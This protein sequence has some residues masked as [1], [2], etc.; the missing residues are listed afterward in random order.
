MKVRLGSICFHAHKFYINSPYG[1]CTN[2]AQDLHY[3]EGYKYNPDYDE[4][5]D[6][7]YLPVDLQTKKFLDVD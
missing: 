7:E 1:K 3:G 5:V 6:Q 4:P 2:I